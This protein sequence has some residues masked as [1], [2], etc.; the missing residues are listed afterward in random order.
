MIQM[1]QV[2][3]ARETQCA[4]QEQRPRVKSRISKKLTLHESTQHAAARLQKRMSNNDLQEALQPS[5]PFFDHAVVETVE[6]DFTRQCGNRNTRALAL[7]QIAEDLEVRV[8]ATHF[9]TAQLESGNI[10]R[11]ADQVCGVARRGRG[12]GLVCLWVCYLLLR[13]GRE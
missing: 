7:E 4:T 10:G 13:E 8:S 6:V 2:G 12:G 1:S 11:E 3:E 5:P 9:G